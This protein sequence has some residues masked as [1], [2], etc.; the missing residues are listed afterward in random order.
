VK[1]KV[2]AFVVLLAILAFSTAI[3]GAKA[4]TDRSPGVHVGDMASYSLVCSAVPDWD[5]FNIS[6]TK[7]EGT[8]VSYDVIFCYYDGT[9]AYTI[10]DTSDV[11]RYNDFIEP[12]ILAGDLSAGDQI[13]EYL[14][15]PRMINKTI[16]MDVAG[17]QRLVNY[18]EWLTIYYVPGVTDLPLIYGEDM[19]WDKAT[20]LTVKA[21][22]EWTPGLGGGWNGWFNWTMTSM[23][24]ATVSSGSDP[25]AVYIIVGCVGFAAILIA[26]LAGTTRRK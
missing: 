12:Y 21:S 22:V 16:T 5:K 19:Y 2:F 18:R 10:H 23:S 11:Q 20:G 3:N 25:M 24:L 4:A 8:I 15:Y 17:S 9:A 26:S 7:I 14:G 6:I 1:K 13:A